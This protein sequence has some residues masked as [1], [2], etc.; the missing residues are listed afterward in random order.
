MREPGRGKPATGPQFGG[1]AVVSSFAGESSVLQTC[2]PQPGK[3]SGAMK[4][5][6]RAYKLPTYSPSLD[7]PLVGCR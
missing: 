1:G 3:Y 5:I 6:N 7:P 2:I 4:N